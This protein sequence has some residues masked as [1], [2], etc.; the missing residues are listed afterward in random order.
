MVGGALGALG[1][2]VGGRGTVGPRL[3]LG[4]QLYGVF[5]LFRSMGF[6]T[7]LGLQGGGAHEVKPKSRSRCRIGL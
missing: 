1:D 5:L 3:L 6:S 2:G 4:A 7:W